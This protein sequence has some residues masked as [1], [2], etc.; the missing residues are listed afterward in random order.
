MMHSRPSTTAVSGYSSLYYRSSASKR[1]CMH[2]LHSITVATDNCIRRVG[3]LRENFDYCWS[4]AI[5]PY[6]LFAFSL[7]LSLSTFVFASMIYDD[8]PFHGFT[9]YLYTQLQQENGNR[10]SFRV[11][12]PM[13]STYNR[14]LNNA[15]RNT[16]QATR[17]ASLW[18]LWFAAH[19]TVVSGLVRTICL[20]DYLPSSYLLPFD[21]CS[22]LSGSLY[23][24]HFILLI[25]RF[26]LEAKARETNE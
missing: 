20:A 5:T 3:K 21:P 26:R 2:V 9:V 7:P 8:L 17:S 13:P 1:R 19:P 15:T 22:M 16:Q 10:K 11:R 14:K 12:N 25:A 24:P 4:S 6:T 23:C 18:N